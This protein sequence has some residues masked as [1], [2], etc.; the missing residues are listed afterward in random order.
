LSG[1][2]RYAPAITS[3]IISLIMSVL[4]NSIRL[5]DERRLEKRHQPAGLKSN[6]E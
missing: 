6:G 3:E 4:Q 1:I 2:G 5:I